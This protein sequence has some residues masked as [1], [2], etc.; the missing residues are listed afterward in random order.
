[1]RYLAYA[2]NEGSMIGAVD[3]EGM[4]RPLMQMDEFYR[5]PF[6]ATVADPQH[7]PIEA[8]SVTAVPLVP[9]TAKILCVGQNY[10][11]HVNEMGG[12]RP[13][14]PNIFARWWSSLTV[15]GADVPLPDNEPGLD[16]EV[17]LAA[18]VGRPMRGVGTD[19][20]MDN[21][22]AY[23][24]FNDISARRHQKKTS[25]WALGKNADR[26]GPIGPTAVTADELGDPYG[27]GLRT[28]VN[29][30]VMQDGSTGDMLFSIA[31][32]LSYASETMTLM[33]G[34][35][36]ATGTPSGVGAG[37]D[38]QRFLGAGDVCEVEVDGIGTLT[39]RVVA[40]G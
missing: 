25:Q 21:I 15:D 29:G 20:V 24:V 18:I 19:D 1:M 31:E 3:A 8:A 14:R 30:E 22:V 16:W 39:N 23:T 33:P 37:M 2:T 34:D 32:A 7:A 5:D 40:R 35:V 17:E 27:R 26:S 10:A 12:T 9:P 28:R 38:P 11:L 6:A 4:I 13:E 36:L